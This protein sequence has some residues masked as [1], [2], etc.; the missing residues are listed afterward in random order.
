MDEAP[1]VTYNKNGSVSFDT[2]RVVKNYL[3][4]L[5]SREQKQPDQNIHLMELVEAIWTQGEELVTLREQIKNLECK[6]AE[7]TNG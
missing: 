7:A 4:T 1:Y 5:K 2:K 6:L 3:K